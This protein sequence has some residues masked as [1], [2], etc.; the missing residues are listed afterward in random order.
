VRD[1]RDLARGNAE[2]VAE[3]VAGRLRSKFDP[4][5]IDLMAQAEYFTRD[6]RAIPTQGPDVVLIELRPERHDVVFAVRDRSAGLL[7]AVNAF[8]AGKP[9]PPDPCGG[10]PTGPP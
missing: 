8:V 7:E 6:D 10:P 2:I 3:A 9:F 1:L 5:Q 4:R